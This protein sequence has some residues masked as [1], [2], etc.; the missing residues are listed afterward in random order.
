MSSLAT[1]R[2]SNPSSGAHSRDPFALPT[3]RTGN[4]QRHLL[5]AALLADVFDA[6]GA[7]FRLDAVRRAA[8]AADRLDPG[9]ALLD[10][11]GLLFHR[12]ADQ[13]LGLLTHRLLRHRP[14]PS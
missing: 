8:F 3:L 6:G 9:I 4:L 7:L 12:L 1:V 5:I 10:D 2:C 11:E 13:A 14:A